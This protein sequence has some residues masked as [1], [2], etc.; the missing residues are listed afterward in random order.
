MAVLLW[1]KP[2]CANAAC[3]SMF[4]RIDHREPW[5]ETKHTVLGELDPLCPHDHDLKTKH[6]WSLVEGTGRRA[7]VPPD[8]ERHPRSR[9]PP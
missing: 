8:D 4:V 9:P 1:S 7:F 3:S 6:G 2:K 5:V